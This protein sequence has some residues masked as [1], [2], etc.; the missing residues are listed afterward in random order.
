MNLTFM[1]V[2]AE[3]L[4]TNWLTSLSLSFTW[5]P[6]GATTHFTL[7]SEGSRAQGL[8]R[9]SLIR[10]RGLEMEKR[11]VSTSYVC[12]L[13]LSSYSVQPK[14]GFRASYGRL[15]FGASSHG[16]PLQTTQRRKLYRS[17]DP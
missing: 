3:L 7:S 17:T 4:H 14:K 8:L 12:L 6:S 10:M 2:R 16:C 9:Y 15:G 11:E 1:K 5:E 13:P